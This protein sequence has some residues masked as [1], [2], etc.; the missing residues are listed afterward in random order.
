[1][2]IGLAA[3]AGGHLTQLRE[4]TECWE[5]KDFFYVTTKEELREQL[6]RSGRT[7]IVGECNRQ[8]PIR[9]L[10]SVLWQCRAIVLRERPDVVI[11]TGAAPALF[12][13]WWAKLIGAKV[14]WIDSIANIE[15]LSLSG[16]LI[17]PCADL[18]LTQWPEVSEHDRKAEYVGAL[19]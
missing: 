3:S 15:R 13:C 12:V 9:T 2:R 4:L 6:Q 10:L 11:S 14:V 8:Y 18:L 16:R 1:M 17:R 5:G 19:L 7:Y